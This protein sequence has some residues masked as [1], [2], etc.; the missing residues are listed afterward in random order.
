[1]EV[2][3]SNAT[4]EGTFAAIFIYISGIINISQWTIEYSEFRASL[5]S[6]LVSYRRPRC[7]TLNQ[8]SRKLCKP[9]SKACAV[10]SD[11]RIN[12]FSSVL[13]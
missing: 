7:K 3:M 13:Q 10:L 2:K 4:G 12:M 11:C 1:M 6:D 9:T 8:V 5:L